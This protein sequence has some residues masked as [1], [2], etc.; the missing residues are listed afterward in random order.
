MDPEERALAASRY[1][2]YFGEIVHIKKVGRRPKGGRYISILGKVKGSPEGSRASEIEKIIVERLN[3]PHDPDRDILR[4]CCEGELLRPYM[5]L[6]WMEDYRGKYRDKRYLC[7]IHS[8]EDGSALI[9]LRYFVRRRYR[10]KNPDELAAV[11]YPIE[12]L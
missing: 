3:A 7:R 12:I 11:A 4:E 5:A 9:V 2:F 1:D 6:P 10:E 8:F